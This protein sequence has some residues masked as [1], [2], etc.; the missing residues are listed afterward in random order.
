MF[1]LC[2]YIVHLFIFNTPLPDYIENEPKRAISPGFYFITC[3]SP[4]AS[5]CNGSTFRLRNHVTPLEGT[6]S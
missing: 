5:Y 2:F 4:N 1:H 3:M 6:Q